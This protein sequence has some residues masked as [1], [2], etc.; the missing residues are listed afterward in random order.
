MASKLRTVANIALTQC[1]WVLIPLALW[2]NPASG[3]PLTINGVGAIEVSGSLAGDQQMGSI[4][5]EK[6]GNNQTGSA[7]S[8]NPLLGTLVGAGVSINSQLSITPTI[9]NNVNGG[10]PVYSH[11]ISQ[12]YSTS[13]A[14]GLND[15]NVNYAFTSS[16]PIPPGCAAGQYSYPT[17]VLQTA[18]QAVGGSSGLLPNS[19]STIP[20][21]I[22]TTMTPDTGALTG[23]WNLTIGANT[24]I[25][26]EPKTVT[27]YL[28]EVLARQSSPIGNSTVAVAAAGDLQILRKWD[29]TTSSM[30]TALRDAEYWLLGYQGG[31]VLSGYT[32]ATSLLDPILSTGPFAI[33]FWKAFRSTVDFFSPGDLPGA[34]GGYGANWDGLIAGCNNM[35]INQAAVD[36]GTHNIY[37]NGGG[38]HILDPI[39]PINPNPCTLNSKIFD[40]SLFQF[41]VNSADEIVYVD[42]AISKEMKYSFAGN[43]VNG[44]TIPSLPAQNSGRFI[45]KFLGE[46]VDLYPDEYFDFL[47]YASDG[48]DSFTLIWERGDDQPIIENPTL[49]FRFA[50]ASQTLLAITSIDIEQSVPEPSTL[51]NLILAIFLLFKVRGIAPQPPEDKEAMSFADLFK[52]QQGNNKRKMV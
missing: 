51:S 36:Y 16:C 44:F 39:L 12:E 21:K 4:T 1:V 2:A 8:F 42:P 47:P 20:Y 14:F 31:Q 22:E 32:N 5:A 30:N 6:Q 29:A 17:Y 11:T 24:A 10:S 37:S 15:I 18:Q 43:M 23:P 41:D 38:T 52:Q 45:V 26:Y 3:S 9:I 46:L 27:Q 13:S 25:I 49:G 7:F 28:Q 35:D 50:N 40:V 19:D 48:V 33:P 34:S